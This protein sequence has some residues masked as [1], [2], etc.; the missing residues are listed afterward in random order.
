LKQHPWED[1]DEAAFVSRLE[2]ELTKIV[3]FQDQKVCTV[4]L[5]K[6]SSMSIKSWVRLTHVRTPVCIATQ[7]LDVTREI[8]EKDDE[9]KALIAT[10]TPLSGPSRTASTTDVTAAESTSTTSQQ[11][12]SATAEGPNGYHDVERAVGEDT[13][14]EDDEEQER[15][16][17]FIELEED[18]ASL[19]A[20]VHDLGECA[21]LSLRDHH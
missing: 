1:S 6:R 3:E 12:P 16:D 4:L 7:V 21:V 17:R 11:R 10:G 13:D 8:A 18:L 19:I 5:R 15:N 2:S 20:D 14:D 9:V